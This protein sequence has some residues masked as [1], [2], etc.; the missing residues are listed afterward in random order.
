VLDKMNKGASAA[1]DAV[2]AR[3]ID[4]RVQTSVPDETDRE[5]ARTL[6]SVVQKKKIKK[7]ATGS[8]LTV[9]LSAA[10]IVLALVAVVALVWVA[11]RPASADELFHQAEGMMAK[12]ENY[13]AALERLNGRDGPVREFLHRYPNDPRAAQ[14]ADWQDLAETHDLLTKLRHNSRKPKFRKE[15]FEKVDPNYEDHAFWAFR[16]EDFGD[17]GFAADRWRAAGK[18]AEADREQRVAASLAHRKL[19]ELSAKWSTLGEKDIK[20]FLQNLLK[21]KLTAA[22][23]LKGERKTK[24]ADEILTEIREL[25]GDDQIVKDLDL[26]PLLEQANKLASKSKKPTK[27]D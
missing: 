26:G 16:Y 23:K 17:V 18:I 21:A 4:R 19:T 10:G 9:L 25:Y 22:E 3:A 11:A 7:K 12:E 15:Y 13:R 2:S 5:A 27:K 1:V 8:M 24:D 20:S 14:V 6:R